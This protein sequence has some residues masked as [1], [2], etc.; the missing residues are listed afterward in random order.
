MRLTG[1]LAWYEEPPL[2]L[3]ECVASL[4]GLCDRV[5]AVDGGYQGLIPGAAGKSAPGQ[6]EA[7]F[8]GAA[9]AGIV[10]DVVVPDEAWPGQVAKRDYLMRRAAN[11]SDWL[12]VV[13]ADYLIDADTDAVRAELEATGLDALDVDF[14]TPLPEGDY[15][16]DVLAADQWHRELAGRTVGMRLL[17]RAL[18]GFQVDEFHWYYSALRDGRRV[19]LWDCGGRYQPAASG[20]LEARLRVD[21]RALLR[22]QAWI[23]RNRAYCAARNVVIES[24]G[25]REP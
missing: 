17:F 1:C 3:Y 6:L 13:D 9:A 24:L 5:V 19:A 23:D 7:I 14:F 4:A 16:L 2:L 8:E 22:G 12:L 21:H 20:E 10:A 18:P 15:D 11:G 25:G